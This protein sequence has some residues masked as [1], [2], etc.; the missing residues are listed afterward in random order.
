MT[1]TASEHIHLLV[2]ELVVNLDRIMVDGV[3]VVNLYVD[4]RS[5]GNIEYKLKGTVLLQILLYL[6]CI[7]QRIAK[8]GNLVVNDITIE[9]FTQHL[10]DNVHLD[11]G[12]K[13]AFNHTNGGLT[14]AE[15]GDIG[16]LAI[17]LQGLLNFALIIILFNGDLKHTIDLVWIFK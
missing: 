6:S 3:L 1:R 17:V 9:L 11:L 14:L 12:A 16:L 4:F 15:S 7:G 8:H 5:N 2:N 10:I 13:L